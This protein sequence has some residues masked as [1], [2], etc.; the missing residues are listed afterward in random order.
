M[1]G[2][3]FMAAVSRAGSEVVLDLLRARGDDFA[4]ILN[5]A[6]NAFNGFACCENGEGKDR[7]D[8]QF[9]AHRIFLSGFFMEG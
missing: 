2:A 3:F 9:L 8:I 1:C 4:G 5:I 6:A 7:E